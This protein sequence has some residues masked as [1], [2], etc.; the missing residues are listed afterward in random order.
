MNWGSI[1]TRAVAGEAS[2][3]TESC[4]SPPTRFWPPSVL[5]F[6]PQVTVRPHH[7]GMPGG[8]DRGGRAHGGRRGWRWPAGRRATGGA[9]A[10][11]GEGEER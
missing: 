9:S 3:I 7:G 8:S 11:A 10:W 1:T 4:V 5:G 6:P 2:T